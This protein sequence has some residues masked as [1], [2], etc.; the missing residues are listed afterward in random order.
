MTTREAQ[1]NDTSSS[2][3]VDASPTFTPTQGSRRSPGLQIPEPTDGYF[4]Y[5]E[6]KTLRHVRL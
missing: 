2:S 5:S 1:T 6:E 3:S 4:G